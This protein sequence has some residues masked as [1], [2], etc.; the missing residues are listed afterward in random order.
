MW[1][2][3]WLNAASGVMLLLIEPGKFLSMTDFYVKLLAIAGA[4]VCMRFIYVTVLLR[5]SPARVPGSAKTAAMA[6]LLFWGVAIT[7]GRLTAYDDA[8]A[9]R[10]TAIA[11]VVVSAIVLVIG[12]AG[13]RLFEWLP[14]T[15]R[16]GS[17][18]ARHDDVGVTVH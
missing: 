11:T 2:G 14:F 1:L 9:Q 16:S 18:S 6:A 13:V 5:S 4:V 7:A 15:R 8:S 12:Y 17:G 10:Q 3:F